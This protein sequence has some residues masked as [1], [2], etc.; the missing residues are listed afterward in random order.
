VTLYTISPDGRTALTSAAGGDDLGPDGSTFVW[1]LE[2]GSRLFGPLP[3]R[4]G[5]FTPDGT[6]LALRQPDRIAFVDAAT[7]DDRSSLM[8]GVT[9]STGLVMSPDGR[10]LAASDDGGEVR[11]FDLPTGQAMG[12][13]LTLFA[14]RSTPLAFL[15]GDR[16]LVGSQNEAAVWSYLDPAPAFATLLPS[17]AS[18]FDARFAPDGEIV[19]TED[20]QLLRARPRDGGPLG[21][22]L[23]LDVAPS[24]RVAV[25][26]DGSTLAVPEADGTVS[27]WD[28]R[29][30]R[31]SSVLPSGQIGPI[32]VA[33]SPDGSVVATVSGSE[34]ALVLWDV[35]DTRDP[36]QRHSFANADVVGHTFRQA[37][38]SKDGRVVVV[39]DFPELGQITFVD[40]AHGRV[41]RTRT[42]G[43]QIGP[44]FRSHDGDTMATMRYL[45]GT[46]L[47]LDAATG[48][49]RATRQV[50]GHPGQWA[51]VHGGRRLAILSVPS[52]DAPGPTSLELWDATTLESMGERV[53]FAMDGWGVGEGDASPDGT[54]LLSAIAKGGA[55]LWDLD[56]EHWETRACRIAGRNLTRAEW[57]EY[58]P[59]REYHR[60]CPS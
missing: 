27:L 47:L 34:R 50:N 26:P 19:I 56:P 31:R 44:V 42:P 8:V 22:V 28:R 46:L 16:L 49:V 20:H 23:D 39:N 29:T 30:G 1:D 36:K 15:P 6:Q 54:K 45:D 51:F 13:S 43:G 40:V 24:S 18:N 38:F 2:S 12:E 52:P 7:G 11:V 58:L 32:A 25:S 53:T 17:D 37:T 48:R 57:N 9:A 35:S 3:G 5:P 21:R 59:G 10:R 4:P 41:L 60:T 55:I 14:D 33:W